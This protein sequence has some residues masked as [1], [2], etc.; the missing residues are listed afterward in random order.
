M[1]EDTELKVMNDAYQSLSL[2][3]DDQAKLRVINWLVDR[4]SLAPIKSRALGL[5]EPEDKTGE[6]RHWDISSFNSVA[7]IFERASPTKERDKV[8]VVGAFLQEKFGKGDLTSAEINKELHHLGHGVKNVTDAISQSI[9]RKPKLMIKTRKEGSTKQARK[10]YKV[11]TE[12]IKAVQR[13]LTAVEDE[14]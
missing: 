11:T 14:A 6:P 4:F 5:G 13:L 8:L 3:E 7:A 10:K 12:G 2:L 9:E 1:N